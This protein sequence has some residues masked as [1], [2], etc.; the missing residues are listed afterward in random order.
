MIKRGILA[1][2]K[3]AI[4]LSMTTLI[5]IVL[6]VVF[7]ILGLVFL[8][9]TFATATKSINTMDKKLEA[10]INKI[11]TDESETF[12][13][14]LGEDRTARVKAGTQNF[15]IMVASQ[16]INN[17]RIAEANQLQYKIELVDEGATS[18]CLTLL[19]KS[20]T[21]SLFF[22]KLD[23]WL[24]STDAN[25][26]LSWRIFTISVPDDTRICTQLVRITAIDKTVIPEGE[27]IAFGT[28]RLEILKKGIF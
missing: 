18:S 27:V 6:G 19:G 17:V 15:G 9:T 12:V 21:T 20:K 2:K 1:D 4:E 26:P 24:D 13:I 23:T 11:F 8:R 22:D 5:T 10:E 3:A 28:F 16:T 7:L 25:G 14:Y